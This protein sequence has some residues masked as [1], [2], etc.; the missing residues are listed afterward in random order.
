[1]CQA[2][3]LASPVCQA[4][5]L[6]STICMRCCHHYPCIKYHEALQACN[7]KATDPAREGALQNV[8]VLTPSNHVC[9]AVLVCTFVQVVCVE[10]TPHDEVLVLA[11]DGL[12]DVFS[13]K[14]R[15]ATH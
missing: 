6:A 1:M 14:V 8:R 2:S 11:T 12:W 5:F 15:Q 13:C 10:R 9:T 3:F 4:S 7:C